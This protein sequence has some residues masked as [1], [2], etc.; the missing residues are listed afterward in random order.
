M[1]VK[2]P[3]SLFDVLGFV[4]SS[5]LLSPVRRRDYRS[6]ILRFCGFV[7][8][9]AEM[10]PADS[11]H[12]SQCL[13][14]INPAQH[15]ISVKTQQNVKSNL[16]GAVLLFKDSTNVVL[17]KQALSD[18]WQSL[19]VLLPDLRYRNGLS[20]FIHYLSVQSSQP[21]GVDD[22]VV[23]KFIDSLSNG[24]FLSDQKIRECH[25]RTTRL[26]NEASQLVAVWPDTL[27]SVPDYRKPRSTYPLSAFPDSFQSEVEEHLVW[28]EDNDLFAKHGP[29]R[30]CKPRTIDLRR[31]Q[32][33]LAASALVQRGRDITE[34]TSLS[35]LVVV[36][37]LKEILRYYLDRHNDEPTSFIH[38]LA[39]TLVSIAEHWLRLPDSALLEIKHVKRQLGSQSVGMTEKNKRYLRQ[40][41]DDQNRKLLLDLP[42]RLMSIAKT[43]SG[44]R[45]AITTQKAIAIELLLM[46]PLR[47]VNVISLQFDKHLVKPGSNRG[48]YHL[49]ISSD[50]IKN[51]QA[52]EVVLPVLLTDYIDAY[53]DYHLPVITSKGNSYLFPDRSTGHKAQSTLSQQIKGTVKQYTG[54]DMTAHLF[55]HLSGK[56]YL[57]ANPGQYETVRQI[58][59][60]KNLKT[61]VDFYT[62]I[63]T[64]EATRVFDALVLGERERLSSASPNREEKGKKKT[65][66]GKGK[67]R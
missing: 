4:S 45:A 49:V 3:P 58:L 47:M 59:G 48:T 36:A 22:S 28:L 61:T 38:S 12:L 24:S 16:L 5:E 19:F 26:W 20:R 29:P 43:Q 2:P 54:L 17:R 56:L 27:L 33:Q 55:R 51:E 15:G 44:E 34:I 63:N 14:T 11:R 66:N 10:I 50:E 21:N 53:R 25:R 60:H 6:S 32:I 57:E 9:S 31:S 23:S 37:S 52:Y 42:Q 30:R 8:K 65:N 40:F 41:D 39:T 35:D 62:G 13:Q 67:K 46:A 18:E 7:G 64:K 1:E